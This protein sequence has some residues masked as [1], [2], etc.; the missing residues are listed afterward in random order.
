MCDA[1]TEMVHLEQTS[2]SHRS[3]SRESDDSA[4]TTLLQVYTYIQEEE[5]E[6]VK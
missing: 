3:A 6:V 2:P 1:V 5:E 4:E